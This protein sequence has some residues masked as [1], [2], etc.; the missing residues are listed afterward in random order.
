VSPKFFDTAIQDEFRPTDKWDINVGAR[1]ESYGYG[2]GDFASASQQFWFNQVNATACVDPTGF[3]QASATDI[4][5]G[6]TAKG[7]VNPGTPRY[8]LTPSNYIGYVTTAPGAACP[9][10]PVLGAQLYHPGS[11]G[12]PLLT[13]GGTG[14][15]TNTTWSPRVGFT[16]TL[17]PN[18]VIRFSYGRYTQPTPTAF[19]QVLTYPDGYKMAS[20]LYDSQYY[21]LGLSSVVH[22]NPIQ[23]ANNFDASYE[24]RLNNT[25]WSFKL[26]PFSHYTV[27]QSVEV[28]LPGGLSGAFN[29]GTEKAQGVELAIQ[30]GDPTKNGFSGQ[31]SYTYTYAQLKYALIDGANIVQTMLNSLTPFLNLEGINGGQ[32]CYGVPTVS[33]AG[34]PFTAAQIAALCAKDAAS[35]S[36]KWVDNPYYYD[37]ITSAQL[38]EQYPLTSFYPTYANF[39]PYGLQTGDA[40]TIIAPNVFSS[41][42]TWKHNKLTAT[43]TGNLWE[44]TTYGAPTEI[45]GINPSSCLAN[46]NR[47]NPGSNLADY[48]TC[49]SSIAIPNPYTGQFDG[50]G[51]Y[52]NPWELNLGAQ[53]G[54]DISTRIHASVLL[55]NI[56]NTCF[57]GSAEPWTAAYAPNSVICSYVPNSTYIGNQP[58]AGYFYGSNPHSALNGTAGYPKLFNQAYAPA[59]NQ[60]AAPFQVYFQANVKL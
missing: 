46:Q 1:F 41:F 21:N 35:A 60:I 18:S 4:G 50:L 22:N 28:S 45:A 30:K 57:G 44:G 51:Q 52:R 25:D 26:S 19:E 13:L 37:T 9:F 33:K 11:H 27:N 43:L 23:F 49:S 17:T 55:A 34:K 7:G 10:D 14:T 40:S 6:G 12:I 5:G 38:K 48:Q 2:L 3:I 56:F 53:I 8:G 36:P 32:P 39:F 20:N 54:Y 31:L 29:S 58:G 15:I 47:I 42:V 24:S 16:Y 59:P